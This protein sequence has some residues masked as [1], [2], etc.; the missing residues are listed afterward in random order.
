[1]ADAHDA[2]AASRDTL[3]ALR[4]V[5]IHRLADDVVEQVRALIMADGLGPGERLPSERDLATRMGTSR[6]IVAQ[7]LRSLSLMGLVEI[8]PGSGAYV[9]RRPEAM[10][11]ASVNLL[12]E[13]EPGSIGHLAELRGW[14]EDV[15]VG[16]AVEVGVRDCLAEIQAALD[17]LRSSAGRASAWVAADTN[18][19]TAVV[20]AAGNPYLGALFANVHAAVVA[21]NYESWVRRDEVP[22]WLRGSNAHRQ[23]ALHEPIVTALERGDAAA[24]HDAVR[25][26]H[27]EMLSH[28]SERRS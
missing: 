23:I 19:H 3:A 22:R 13:V 8:R 25:R 12:L 1:M 27:E 11:S 18:F 4:P 14:L 17:K 24:A 26:H 10:F 6:A 7:A 5:G 20:R 15:A 28:L 2:S 21:V 9:T 16:A